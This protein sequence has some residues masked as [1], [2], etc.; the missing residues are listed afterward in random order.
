MTS[1]QLVIMPVLACTEPRP[2]AHT[3]N[4][5]HCPLAPT[6]VRRLPQQTSASAVPRPPAAT[7]TLR[8]AA[9]ALLAARSIGSSGEQESQARPGDLAS[10]RQALAW[11]GTGEPSACFYASARSRM[12]CRFASRWRTSSFL[13]SPSLSIE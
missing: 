13:A 12:R 4:G 1:R 10:A 8:R 5:S 6:R 2:C 3:Y 7:Q 9:S 11:G